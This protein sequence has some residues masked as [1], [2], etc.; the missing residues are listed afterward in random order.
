MK[1]NQLAT[2]ILRLIG[3]Y[4]LVEAVPLLAIN[5]GSAVLTGE[6]AGSG[7]SRAALAAWLV[8]PP[9]FR[10]VIGIFLLIRAEALAQKL[11]SQDVSDKTIPP[12]T[13]EDIQVFVFAVTGILIFSAALPQLFKSIFDSAQSLTDHSVYWAGRWRLATG[14][15]GILIKAALGLALFF[16][17]RGFANFWR[18]LRQFGTPKLPEA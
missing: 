8:L 6:P 11:A 9:I 16:R 3:I 17:A 7:P 13:F 10:I 18:S 14:A 5:I 4:S 12:V 1:A 2:L 15:A